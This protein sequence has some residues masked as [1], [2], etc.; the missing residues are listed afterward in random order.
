MRSVTPGLILLCASLSPYAEGAATAK[1]TSMST[2]E[3]NKQQIRRLYDDCINPHRPALLP[4]LVDDEFTNARGE[5]G[6]AAF[7]A[8][9][10]ALR[11][12]FPD[13]H[14]D[15]EDVVAEGD[16]VTVRWL[17]KGT[18]TGPFGGVAPSRRLV[19]NEGMA[20]FQLRDGKIVRIWLQTDRLGF[21]Q[22]LGVVPKDVGAV[23]GPPPR[24]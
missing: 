10:E 15:V 17:W 23:A 22:A 11:A 16:R 19:S 1:E 12:G 20:I 3:N 13:I 14:Y 5:R 18:H 4:Q 9:I 21:L 24:R 8:G 7:N 6:P 2:I